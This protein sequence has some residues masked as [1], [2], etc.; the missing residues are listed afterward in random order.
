MGPGMKCGRMKF[1]LRTSRTAP[2]SQ[3]PSSP[4]NGAVGAS[5]KRNA[6]TAT[7]TPADSSRIR[8]ERKMLTAMVL[9][10]AAS[11]GV[12]KQDE[13]NAHRYLYITNQI[14]F[15][16]KESQQERVHHRG[17]HRK[18]VAS[19]I[20]ATRVSDTLQNAHQRDGGEQNEI[21]IAK[22]VHG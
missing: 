22:I 18:V 10:E 12:R 7:N 2:D 13:R 20:I 16:G 1:P 3:T 19:A 6:S 5:I 14:A 15:A 17:R 21:V 4:V 8:F 11:L 9:N